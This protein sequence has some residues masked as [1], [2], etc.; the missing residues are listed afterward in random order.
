MSIADIAANIA[1][2]V[3]STLTWPFS[4]VLRK[5]GWMK[6]LAIDKE[7][8]RDEARKMHQTTQELETGPPPLALGDET[9]F[10]DGII[11]LEKNF[12]A[13]SRYSAVPLNLED[14]HSARKNGA[15]IKKV[16][17]ETNPGRKLTIFELKPYSSF[18]Q[19]YTV[20]SGIR[21]SAKF[22]LP[23]IEKLIQGRVPVIIGNYTGVGS[24]YGLNINHSTITKDART[25]IER[26]LDQYHKLGVIGHS[27][28]SAVS[29]RVV[30]QL[31][32]SRPRDLFGDM[33]MVSP[34]DKFNDVITTYPG[35]WLKPLNALL[36][37]YSSHI[38]YD[39]T[40]L[41]HVWDTGT[42][43][44]IAIKNLAKY[45]EKNPIAESQKLR[46]HLFHGTEDPVVQVS[47]ADALYKRLE[48][49]IKQ[50]APNIQRHFEITLH[51]IEGA[52][53]FSE[54]EMSNLPSEVILGK[55]NA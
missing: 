3:V 22:K 39:K 23:L 41:A 7:L 13:G 18:K 34:W 1:Y 10:V 46:I 12:Y 5:I 44:S 17:I 15:S 51:K 9:S 48:T 8:Q 29:A 26:G 42:N 14:L 20:L 52:Q 37:W 4:S 35:P 16:D 6:P 45:L 55:I 28:G 33:I 11:G 2:K 31:S 47:Q 30:A 24:T 54:G 25:M 36:S 40:T 53:H 50:L 21:S 19:A 49:E 43:L 32:S 38:L 27:L